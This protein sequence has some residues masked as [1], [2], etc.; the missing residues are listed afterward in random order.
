MTGAFNIHYQVWIDEDLLEI[1][2]FTRHEWGLDWKPL[3]FLKAHF[4]RKEASV[5]LARRR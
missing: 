4:Y 1:V 3:V 5:L 2:E